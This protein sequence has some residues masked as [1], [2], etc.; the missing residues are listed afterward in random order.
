M[1][2]DIYR[3]NKFL[4]VYKILGWLLLNKCYEYSCFPLSY[5]LLWIHS[6]LMSSIWWLSWGR[7]LSWILLPIWFMPKM[8]HPNQHLELLEVPSH[9][10][11]QS[12][13]IILYPEDICHLETRWRYSVVWSWAWCNKLCWSWQQKEGDKAERRKEEQWRCNGEI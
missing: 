1:P 2:K 9:Q 5:L 7:S 11:K 10:K 4:N 12:T 6:R 13:L 3:I 8:K